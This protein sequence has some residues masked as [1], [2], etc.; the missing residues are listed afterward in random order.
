MTLVQLTIAPT[1]KVL[2]ADGRAREDGII[3]MDLG[4]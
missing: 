1:I 2:A 3:K 4:I